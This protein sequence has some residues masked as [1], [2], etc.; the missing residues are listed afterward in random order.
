MSVQD[1]V[2]GVVAAVDDKGKFH[3]HSGGVAMAVGA[4]VGF[5]GRHAVVGSEG[6][7]KIVGVGPVEND[8]ATACAFHLG[9]DVF[10]TTNGM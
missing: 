2:I 6:V 7:V 5:V 3:D 10:P 9:S 1:V 8:D 4:S